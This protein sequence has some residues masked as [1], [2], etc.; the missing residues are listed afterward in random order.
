M[1]EML[2]WRSSSSRSRR[3]LPVGFIRPA[4]PTLVAKPPS[5]PGWMHEVEHDGYRLLARKEDGRVKLWT[6]YG[7]DYT[8]QLARIAEAVRGLTV[9]RALIDGEAVVFRPD[10]HC[11]FEA[12]RTKA[13]AARA[14]YVV[15]DL[16]QLGGKD[17]RQETLEDRRAELARIVGGKSDIL[18]NEAFE[19]RARLSSPRPAR[20]ASRA[21]SQ[22]AWGAAIRR[23]RLGRGSRR[24]T[25]TSP[26]LAPS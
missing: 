10:G 8:D 9:E 5:G 19:P 4:Q 1:R 26:G 7:T 24:K 23:A 17:I 6:R 13:G 2:H 18:F 14:A 12:L 21:S 11:N 22:S 25:R 16:I 3:S 15:F 20:W